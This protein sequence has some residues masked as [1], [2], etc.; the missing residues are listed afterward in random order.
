MKRNKLSSQK[1]LSI[2]LLII[3]L[4]TILPIASLAADLPEGPGNDGDIPVPVTVWT[5]TDD[6]DPEVDG[7]YKFTEMAVPAADT[8]TDGEYTIPVRLW[9][10]SKNQASMANGA[11]EQTATLEVED[12][13]GT[14]QL[15]FKPLLFSGLTAHL[16][17]LDLLDNIVFNENNYPEAYDLI[18]ADVL[19]NYDVWDDYNHPETGSD[20]RCKG[21]PYPKDLLVPITLGQEYTWAHVY[22]P[23]MATTGDGDQLVRIKLDWNGLLPPAPVVITGVTVTPSTVSVQKGASRQFTAAVT[24]ENNP[25]QSVTWSVDGKDSPGTTISVAGLLTVAADETAAELTV[26]AASVADASKTGAA[27]VTVT[28]PPELPGALALS[29]VLGRVPAVTAVYRI[30]IPPAADLYSVYAILTVPGDTET[31]MAA[32]LATKDPAST[33]VITDQTGLPAYD[34]VSLRAAGTD[35]TVFVRVTPEAGSPKAFYNITVRREAA[36]PE[37]IADGEYTIPVSLWHETR[38]QPSMGNNGLKQTAK[39]TVE[40]GESTLDMEFVPLTIPIGAVE[41]TGYLANLKL[42]TNIQ[43]SDLGGIES[44]SLTDALVR[45]RYDGVWDSYNHP[46]TGTD[47]N[48]KG[49]AY[50]KVVSIPVETETEYTYVQVYVPVMEAISG[51][52]GGGSQ[53]ARVKLI[54]NALTPVGDPNP[55]LEAAL[56][57]GDGDGDGVAELTQDRLSGLSGIDNVRFSAGGAS[58]TIPAQYLNEMFAGDPGATLRFEA[59]ESPAET[60]TALF[61]ILGDNGY[62]VGAFDLSLTLGMQNITDLGGLVKIALRL[63]DDQVA[64]LINADAG[65]WQLFYYNPITEEPETIEAGFNP[66]DK[67]VTFRTNHLSTYAIATAAA[68]NPGVP[69]DPGGTKKDEDILPGNYTIAVSALKEASNDKSMADQFFKER[70]GLRVTDNEITVTVRM[71]GTSSSP[72]AKDGIHMTS[73]K[74]LEYKNSSGKWVN[75]VQSLDTEMDILTIRLVV[76]NIKDPVY[77]RVQADEMGSALQVFRLVF[78]EGSLRSGSL[79]SPTAYTIE[80]TAGE[81]GVI[82][83]SGKVKVSQGADKT[84]TITPNEGYGVKE[85]LVDKKPV[86]AVESYTFKAVKENHAISVTFEQTGPLPALLPQPAALLGTFTD[87]AGHWAEETIRF[88]VGTGLFRGTAEDTFSPDAPMTRGMFVTVL[89]RFAGLDPAQYQETPF[90]DVEADAYYAPYVAWAA[91]RGLVSGVGENR[92]APE[93]LITRE[94]VAAILTNYD[95]FIGLNLTVE[96]E[97]VP[98]PGAGVAQAPEGVLPNGRYSV[99]TTALKETDDS[100]SMSDQFLTERAILTVNN[101]RITAAMTWHGTEFITMDMLKELKYQKA[102]GTFTEVQRE[103]STT[104]NTMTIRFEI[105]GLSKPTVFQVYVPAGM[106]ES[107]PRFRLALDLDTLAAEAG[108]PADLGSTTSIETFADEEQISP[109]AKAGVTAM[110][111]AGIFRGDDAN[112]FNPQNPITRAEGATI[113]ARILGFA[114]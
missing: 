39:L 56:E 75:A 86:D 60:K 105:A 2:C 114:G 113:F 20:S 29:G 69:G 93:N 85:V 35:T 9:H 81:G 36:P 82:S 12:G 79:P 107:R 92:L 3:M 13:E 73:V 98:E 72:Q 17:E 18:P 22:V 88:I 109:W 83:P 71:H 26:T 4:L 32:D 51:G 24:G 8:I 99:E 31:V 70:A 25:P 50:P 90:S 53:Y 94:E 19:T 103:L 106:G 63:T 47:A 14:L 62:L 10:A 40:D 44:A 78:D 23:V 95:A 80:A 101:G 11:L 48:V 5:Y 77:L 6:Y 45:S 112:R 34:A 46:D 65:N 87:I 43:F 41:V 68:V 100:L 102:D 28:A 84:F 57:I 67:T 89:G 42:V 16:F 58:L 76:Y 33:A 37:T 97:A 55:D 91:E 38:D 59:R 1:M 64:T 61:Q 52:N 108:T 104:G 110:Q 74:T 111:K 54:W 15:T 30:Y 66:T 96:E 21:L 7:S 49:T 27:A